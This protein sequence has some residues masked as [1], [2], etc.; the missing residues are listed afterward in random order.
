M[1]YVSNDFG[2]TWEEIGLNLPKEPVNVIKEDPKNENILYVGTDHGV[3]VS[4]DRGKTF[5]AFNE[6]LP[7]VAVHDLVI[8]PRENDLVI[9]THGRS[10]YIAN[11][12]HV[13]DLQKFAEKEK[14]KLFALAEI[15]FSERWGTKGWT[16]AEDFYE[17]EISVVIYSSAAMKGQLKVM[18]KDGEVHYS[19]DVNLDKG[20]NYLAYNLQSE[21]S[22]EDP[23]DNGK[24]YLTAGDYTMTITSEGATTKENFTVKEPRKRNERKE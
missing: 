9:G 15:S 1:I 14:I 19:M 23:K 8:H 12:S 21:L 18:D 24:R 2:V 7:A 11:I 5:M 22:K 13:Q 6:G 17:P 3:Y 10:I 16:W 4:L 20:L